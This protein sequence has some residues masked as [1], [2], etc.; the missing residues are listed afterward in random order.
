MDLPTD[1]LNCYCVEVSG[2]DARENFFVEKTS[3]DWA[4]EGRKEVSLNS[5]L[6]SGCVVFVRLIQSMTPG[7][8]FPVAYQAITLD[9]K[10]SLG[11]AR[12]RLQPLRPRSQLN[13][14]SELLADSRLQLA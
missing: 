14:S 5:P 11:R 13:A 8:S 12:V 10:N 7:N 6:R 4:R 1:E 9:E 2:W 3:L